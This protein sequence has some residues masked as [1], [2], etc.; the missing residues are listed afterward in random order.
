MPK[1]IAKL[2]KFQLGNDMRSALI[3]LRVLADGSVN[4]CVC[5]GWSHILLDGAFP[6]QYRWPASGCVHSSVVAR[7]CSD[8]GCGQHLQDQINWGLQY[9]D[10]PDSLAK[11]FASVTLSFHCDFCCARV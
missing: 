7:G 10:E 5:L 11:R 8:L 3:I 2:A 1:L 9:P 6:F 4:D